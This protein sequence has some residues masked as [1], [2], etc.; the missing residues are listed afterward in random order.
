MTTCAES[1]PQ[2]QPGVHPGLLDVPLHALLEM[3]ADR[4]D[5]A[6]GK[7]LTWSHK[8]FI[9]LTRLCRDV[10]SYCTFATTPS[11]LPAPFL[12]LEEVLAIA[13]EGKAAGCNEALF[14]LGDKPE[15]RYAE[16]REWLSR[17]GYASTLAYLADAAAL[18]LRETGLLPHLNPGVATRAELEALRPF[19]ASF[20]MMLETVSERLC[21]KG[22]PH[23]GSPDKQ[24]Q[25]RL[26]CLRDAGLAR[27]PTTTGLLIGIGDTREE[28]LA[29]L[30]AIAALHR[31]HGHI[32]E[33]I[34]Q[35][36][37][38]KPATRMADSE[39]PD[40]DE[41]LWTVAAARLVLPDDVGLQTPPNLNPGRTRQL[42]AAGINDWGGMSKVTPD[43]VNP[44]APWPAPDML[45]KECAEAG[46][47]L[48]ERLPIYPRIVR[49]LAEWAEP[50]MARAIRSRADGAGLARC[51]AWSPGQVRPAPGTIAAPLPVAGARTAAH[52]PSNLARI[53]SGQASAQ[54]IAQL[55]DARGGHA[56]AIIAYADRLRR[57]TNGDDVTYV[58][59][60][61]IN[62]TNICTYACKFCAF[63]KAS[64]KGGLR[65]KPYLL[66]PSDVAHRAVEAADRG[67]TEVCLQGGIH[68]DFDGSTYLAICEA[69]HNACPDMHIHAFSPLEISH[70]ATTLGLSVREFLGLLKARGLSS[71]PGTAAEILHD[72]VRAT[73]C[74]D[75]LSTS[76]WLSVIE[77]AHRSGIRTTAT[78]MFGHI[79][80]YD[81]WAAHLLAIRD[82]QRRTGGFTEFVPLPFVHMEAPAFLRGHARPG[83]T[84]REVVLMHAIARIV[85]HGQI[86]NIQTSW[87]KLGIAGA[88][89]CLAAGANDVGGVLMDESISRAAGAAHGQWLDL[90]ALESELGPARPL[91]CRSTFYG[92]PVKG[93]PAAP[94]AA[95][96]EARPAKEKAE[97]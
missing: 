64:S 70:G 28:R 29:S 10:C 52:A 81:H 73:L 45:D 27:M 50:G 53:A 94:G 97:V 39:E 8:V 3:A 54:E 51:D 2:E 42:I 62:Y 63:S 84:W 88:G 74:P 57:E 36:F 79:D 58:V 22:G 93:R 35:N 95:L 60:R 48:A 59:N 90:P 76:E 33:V 11:R 12:E 25:V 41:L 49:E 66:S 89:A 87:V 18:V 80:R 72:E 43:H 15:L 7:R 5:R 32:Q 16:A 83:P 92:N 65:D 96:P 75:K 69:V 34:V 31:E 21:E 9:P 4:R 38:A 14:T 26:D 44:E 56:N 47:V 67:A 30:E 20:G 77:E 85:L 1:N 24:P 19:A 13:R 6:W 46:F 55:F 40:L 17:R 78:I 82:L 23:F 71:L 37:R 61:N 86:D 91:R 68:P